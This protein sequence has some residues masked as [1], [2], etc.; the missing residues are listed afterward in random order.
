MR[1]AFL[2]T[3]SPTQHAVTI[4]QASTTGVDV[5]AALN[6]ISDN[7]ETSAVYI[8][9]HETL[10]RGTVKVTHTNG[11]SGAT[12]DTSSSALSVDLKRGRRPAPRRRGSS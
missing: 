1:A 2:K 5:V 4:Y 11:G 9:G 6:L 12:D 10:P 8:S 7:R 3:T